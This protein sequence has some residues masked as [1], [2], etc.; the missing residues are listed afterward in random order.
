MSIP[1][2]PYGRVKENM[3]FTVI[4]QNK[5]ILPSYIS[6]EIKYQNIESTQY[7]VAKLNI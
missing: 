5:L 7:S 4:L 3:N 6:N 2:A 1:E